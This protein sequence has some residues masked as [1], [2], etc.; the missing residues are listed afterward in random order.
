V[1]D[2]SLIARVLA[3]DSGAERELSEAHVDRVFRRVYRLAGDG[4]RAQDYTQ[5]T[6]IRA[7]ERLAEFRRL[8]SARLNLA[9]F[10]TWNFDR[11]QTG[12]G[13]FLTGGLE[14]RNF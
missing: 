10:R 8:Q 12:E 7:F 4:D 6:F 5:E 14:F 1:D 11:V 2:R 13:Y 9:T 3:G